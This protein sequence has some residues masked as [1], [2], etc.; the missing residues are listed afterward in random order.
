MADHKPES[1]EPSR[2][3]D[4]RPFQPFSR[5]PSSDVDLA[6]TVA[7]A[8]SAVRVL[9]ATRLCRNA[10]SLGGPET[11]VCHPATSTH[12]SLP[13]EDQAAI[14]ITPVGKPGFGATAEDRT[15]SFTLMLRV[16]SGAGRRSRT[17]TCCRRSWNSRR[18]GSD[19]SASWYA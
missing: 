6:F 12:V 1:E 13:P 16:A 4:D 15:W 5:M 9:R 14:G 2:P 10:V 8:E 3:A 11:L 17:G 19:V 18:F 7:D